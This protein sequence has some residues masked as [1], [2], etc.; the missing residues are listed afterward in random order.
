MRDHDY[1]D[2]TGVHDA[3][4]FLHGL[5]EGDGWD[6]AEA[7][8]EISELKRAV[9]QAMDSLDAS[10]EEKVIFLALALW[11]AY[12]HR[13]ESTR[14]LPF[15]LHPGVISASGLRATARALLASFD[16]HGPLATL[17]LFREGKDFPKIIAAMANQL[18][19]DPDLQVDARQFAF[20]QQTPP[21]AP[22][23]PGTARPAWEFF[24]QDALRLS[25][26]ALPF[27]QPDQLAPGYHPARCEFRADAFPARTG[28]S[29]Q[30]QPNRRALASLQ[31]TAM[32]QPD[33]AGLQAFSGTW[34][35]LRGEAVLY[36]GACSYNL[37]RLNSSCN[38]DYGGDEAALARELPE[39]PLL[40]EQPDGKLSRVPSKDAPKTCQQVAGSLTYHRL[41]WSDEGQVGPAQLQQLHRLRLSGPV[42]I[43]CHQ[44][45][46]R[47]S[48][49][50][51]A[52]ALQRLQASSAPD[53]E[54]LPEWGELRQAYQRPAAS[55]LPAW[56]Q[57]GQIQIRQQK[58]HRLAHRF[59]L[60]SC[61]A[62]FSG[63]DQPDFESWMPSQSALYQRQHQLMLDNLTRP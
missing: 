44:G 7:G 58:A 1:S 45:K 25:A 12:R 38:S 52:L 23:A 24:L 40:Q 8:P 43:T 54:H 47:S 57:A 48:L 33:L 14:L 31:L 13:P 4:S 17:A 3:E 62:Q 35:N 21:P 51:T 63:C 30:S 61:Y 26:N 5:D 34:L 41:C 10:L 32:G 59:A 37:R 6:T 11:R 15:G 46:A 19:E 27:G 55:N 49:A 20:D 18:L 28:H 29:S 39:V 53:L 60:L 2:L 16:Q 36:F 50:L 22:V 42:L 56:L 9:L